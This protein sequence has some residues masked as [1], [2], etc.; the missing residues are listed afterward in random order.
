MEPGPPLSR[1][2]THARARERLATVSDAVHGG[3]G[4]YWMVAM[5]M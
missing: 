5:M 3:A 4:F 1:T 2:H